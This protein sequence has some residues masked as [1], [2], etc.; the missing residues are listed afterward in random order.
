MLAVLKADREM[1]LSYLYHDS[2][3]VQRDVE[4]V[5][6]DGSAR[7][8]KFQEEV[9]ILRESPEFDSW[10]KT[11]TSR[12][13]FMN[14]CYRN[15]KWDFDDSLFYWLEVSPMTN[16]CGVLT[17]SYQEK[18]KTI[19]LSFFC[20]LD[21]DAKRGPHLM[22]G[23]LIG[24]LVQQYKDFDYSVIDLLDEHIYVLCLVFI[25]LMR[26]LPSNYVVYCLVDG[27]YFL[28]LR[29]ERECRVAI[30]ILEEI[31]QDKRVKS[32]FKCLVTSPFYTELSQE[33]FPRHLLPFDKHVYLAPEYND[34]SYNFLFPN[35]VTASG[36]PSV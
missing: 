29:W 24:Q 3:K 21:P 25:R 32:T 20:G 12:V 18:R 1:V 19:V 36:N 5:I 28:D 27:V 13:L 15:L 30:A 23:S 9:R 14:G 34:G 22:L 33:G 8:P 17:R 10:F 26:Q 6:K 31:V 2:S 16:L 7:D 35:L 4:K 11:T